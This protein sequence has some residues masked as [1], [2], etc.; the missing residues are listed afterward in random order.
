M[1]IFLGPYHFLRDPAPANF[2]TGT[3]LM[4]VLV[5]AMAIVVKKP[6]RVWKAILAGVAVTIW[7]IAGT[8]GEGIGV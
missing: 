7:V 6:F 8:L 2:W 5:G 1:S 3:V 4:V